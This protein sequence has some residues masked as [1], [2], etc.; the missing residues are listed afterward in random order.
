MLVSK[1]VCVL[2]GQTDKQSNLVCLHT[3]IT[4]AEISPVQVP[5]DLKI[6]NLLFLSLCQASELCFLSFFR[7]ISSSQKHEIF[8]YKKDKGFSLMKN[9]DFI[10]K[11]QLQ[12]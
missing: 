2:V 5:I 3:K 1:T 12:A 11:H 10:W 8:K 4:K 7:G 6:F 9:K